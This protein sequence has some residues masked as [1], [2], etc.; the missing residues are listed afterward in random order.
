MMSVAAPQTAISTPTLAVVGAGPKGLAIAAK[1]AVL[2]RLGIAAPEVVLLDPHGVAAHWSGAHGYTD[3]RRL[4]GTA[5]EK[6]VGFPYDS[7]AW[8]EAARNRAVDAAML[9]YSWSAHLV[10]T[11]KYSAWID[12]D[13]VRPTHRDWSAYLRWVGDAAQPRVIVGELAGLHVAPPPPS[14][15]K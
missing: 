12:R 10:A 1:Q 8:G 6:D 2:R 11:Y 15:T 9:G 7:R 3:G 13:R 4:L 14:R 5:P